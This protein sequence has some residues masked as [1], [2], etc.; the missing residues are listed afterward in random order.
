[1]TIVGRRHFAAQSSR[2]DLTRLLL[3]AG[4]TVDTTNSHSNT[5]SEPQSS[6]RGQGAIIVLLHEYG[7]SP[8]L[9]NRHGVSPLRLARNIGNDVTGLIAVANVHIT[10]DSH[11]IALEY[12]RSL[13][14][15]YVLDG[16]APTSA[17]IL[18]SLLQYFS[19]TGD[20]A[21]ELQGFRTD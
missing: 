17:L 3:E 16:L 15:P 10:P 2:A 14:S 19:K 20:D 4:A 1:M 8:A 18:P 7:A 12:Y 6:S 9:E 21:G 11:A 5:P 13:G